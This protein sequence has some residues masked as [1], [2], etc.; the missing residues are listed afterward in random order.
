M[1]NLPQ[2]EA[3]KDPEKRD[4]D[5]RGEKRVIP[6]YMMAE[7]AMLFTAQIWLIDTRLPLIN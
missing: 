2:R 7:Q 1:L 6:A 4:A 3:K 5:S